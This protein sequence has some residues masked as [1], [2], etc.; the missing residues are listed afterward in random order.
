MGYIVL[1]VVV[2]IGWVFLKG[3]EGVSSV[4]DGYK[5]NQALR[6]ERAAKYGTR[7][8]DSTKGLFE[9]NLDIIL[10]FESKIPATSPR[11]SSYSRR[12]YSYQDHYLENETRDCI[13]EIALAENKPSVRPNT[14]YFSNWRVSA[15][16]DWKDLGDAILKRFEERQKHLQQVEQ[17]KQLAYQEGQRKAAALEAQISSARK[18]LSNRLSKR[19]DPLSIREVTKRNSSETFTVEDLA[20]I[21][22]ANQTTWVESLEQKLSQLSAPSKLSLLENDDANKTVAAL[23]FEISLFNSSLDDDV[24]LQKENRK[25]FNDL[26]AKYSEGDKDSVITRIGYVLND[27]DLPKSVPQHWNVDFDTAEGIAIVEI[28]LP[29]VVHT[30]MYKVVNLKSG[31]V[32]KPLNQTEFKEKVPC[33]HPAIL[34][35]IAYEIYRND[36]KEVIKLL[37]VNG[38]VEFD[39]PSTGNKT[40]MFTASMA[41]TR[42]QILA[43]NL[44]KLDPISAFASLKGK[45]AGKLIDMI[46]VTPILTIDRKD[47]RFI[48]TR[49][50]LNNLSS[51]TNL[52]VMDWQDFENLI[53]QLFEKEFSEEGTE[54]KLTQSSRDKGVDAIVINPDPIRGGKYVI[55]AKRYAHTVDVSAVRDLVAVVAHEG[56]SRGILVT[57][58]SFGADAYAFV[59]GKP[60]TLL[61]GPK[62]LGLLE[63]HGYTFRINLGEAKKL[64]A[65]VSK[66]NR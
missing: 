60:I 35:R 18:T 49:E 45:S 51:S 16:K 48:E 57:T 61:D 63:K 20:K 66:T 40:K 25:F 55:Q 9:R 42:E 13:N 29:D 14:A 50:V 10:S 32:L 53:A 6:E 58:S 64:N 31:S 7:V 65:E 46:P 3:I 36:E 54:I 44:S 37:V 11:T 56:A 47:K 4:N 22:T 26:N 17:Q 1:F 12:G 41:V 59:Q 33:I 24:R 39:D 8:I 23:N 43:L 27:L 62:L 21:L 19:R 2:G 28:K 38:L 30:P 34:L 15:P 52:A 5:K